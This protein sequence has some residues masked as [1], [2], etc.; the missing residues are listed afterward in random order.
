VHE[1]LDG[2][3]DASLAAYEGPDDRFF[4]VFAGTVA[5]EDLFSAAGAAARS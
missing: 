5:P 1:G 4:G 2:D 3:L